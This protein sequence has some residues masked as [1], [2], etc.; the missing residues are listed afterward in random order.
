[1]TRTTS[2]STTITGSQ[3]PVLDDELAVTG[4]SVGVAGVVPGVAWL[5][6]APG[7]VFPGVGVV[8]VG[9]GTVGWVGVG[10]A[11]SLGRLLPPVAW[12]PGVGSNRCVHPMP[13]R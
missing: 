7:P 12:S 8:T 6:V 13:S 10:A 5:P 9:G 11:S 2:A 1:M 3:V 4:A